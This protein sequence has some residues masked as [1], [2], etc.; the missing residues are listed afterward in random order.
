MNV[1]KLATL[2]ALCVLLLLSCGEKL[3]DEINDEYV[4]LPK[5]VDYNFDIKP[6]LSDRC[7]SCHGPDELARKGGLRLDVEKI[8]KSKL[9]SGNTALVE[10]NLAKSAVYQHI[11]SEEED[12]IMPPPDSKL[13][14][15]ARDK[16]MIVKWIEQGAEYK[17]HW[18]FIAPVKTNPPEPTTPEWKVNNEIDLFIQKS[19]RS[20]SLVPSNEASKET[21][22]KRVY[23]DLTGLPPKLDDI[24][25]FLNDN[26][27]EAY[28]KVVDQLLASDAGAER[29]AMEWMD[30]ARY[31][32]SHGLHADGWRNAWPW[33]DWV[34]KA[35]Q[36]NMSYDQFVTEQL[37][38]D[39]LPNPTREQILATAFHRNH[40][41]TA[42]GGAIDEEFRLEY[43]ADRTNTTAT[44]LMGLT[45][46]CARCHD[47]KF[48]PIS[49]K[50]YYA[51]SAFFNNVREVGMTGDDGNYGPLLKLTSPETDQKLKDLQQSIIQATNEL[52]KEAATIAATKQY[53]TR[54]KDQIHQGQINHLSFEKKARNP[55]GL[56]IFDGNTSVYANGDPPL[57]E[58]KI[59]KA[60][61]F[62]NEYDEVY[63][64]EVPELDVPTPA[65][66]AMW[67]NTKKRQLTKTQVL[68]GN[69]GNKNNYWRGWDF[70]LEDNNQ[71]SLRLINA[72]PHNLIHVKTQDSV[73]LN[74]WTHVAFS[75][76]GS[77]KAEGV[78]IYINGAQVSVDVI[79]NR[80]Y[81]NIRTI[82]AGANEEVHQP[83]RISKSYRAFTGDN[84]IFKG[85]IDE[86]YLYN[87]VLSSL[88]IAYLAGENTDNDALR[89]DHTL[90]HNPKW[91]AL[92]KKR[93]DLVQEM[94]G[95]MDTVPEVMVMEEMNMPRATHVLNRG[96]YDA[97]GE[98]VDPS[99]PPEILP[100]PDNLPRNRLG[101][102][103]WL[104]DPKHPLTARATVNRY[105]QMIFGRGIVQTARDF[106]NQ[107][108]LPSHPELLDWLAVTFQESGWDVRSLL[109]S[110]VMSAT[111]RQSSETDPTQKEK[112]PENIYLSRGVTLRWP[113]EMIRDN[114]LAASGLL[115]RKIGGP[116]VKPY[117]PE[118]LW[119]EK[120]TFSYKLLRYI[121]DEGDGLYRRSL[122]TFIKRTS[123]PPSMT[124]FDVPSRDVCHISRESTNTP[125]QALV[126]LNDPQYVEAARILGE[127]MLREG[128]ITLK[129]Q[130]VYGFRLVTGRRPI[131]EEVEVLTAIYKESLEEFSRDNAKATEL[132]AVGNRVSDLQL[133]LQKRA[134]MAM[135]GSTMLNMDE[136]YMK[137]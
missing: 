11:I 2:G 71:I 91:L 58:G 86:I 45:M 73:L 128:G 54:V 32:D 76:D 40:P 84:G 6:I 65:S 107:G 125:L 121:P 49:Q 100:F 9:E 46:E 77:G 123:P 75:Y 55:K 27:S 31:A 135:V 133:P 22:L 43:V 132:L 122:Y 42:E 59:G 124:I 41:M 17:P 13:H 78:K 1:I 48:D 130:M 72:L 25:A 62:D 51:L 120:G 21:L 66:A 3:P 68:I 96:Q 104:F 18:A 113:A 53:L 7:Y 36:S 14:L 92:Q 67:I 16:A 47:H 33:R 79:Y 101:L 70:Y 112:D 88:E 85:K 127:R 99:T 56:N 10:H 37:A 74:T 93:N 34:I 12:M 19:L 97:P 26:S 15:S 52:E 69:A 102:A 119:I 29:L 80:L 35:F 82:S 83:L 20:H 111:Y 110:F 64:S 38:G 23:M 108:A 44:A 114:A 109:K 115:V 8:S 94:I 60:V 30:V 95:L 28:E 137:R 118:G 134:A 4:N 131:P 57:V 90:V 5:Y 106:G 50:D 136:A 24:D 39:L 103:I 89:I 87:R 129:D 61:F 81:K 116:S 126:L 105:W 117:Q 63:L 98:Q